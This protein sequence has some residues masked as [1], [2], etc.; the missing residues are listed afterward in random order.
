MERIRLNRNRWREQPSTYVPFGSEHV[1]RGP[2]GHEPRSRKSR[3][4]KGVQRVFFTESKRLNAPRRFVGR[5]GCPSQAERYPE[6]SRTEYPRC[7]FWLADCQVFPSQ[8]LLLCYLAPRGDAHILRKLQRGSV[9][10]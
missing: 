3:C 2:Q 8:L 7:I 1:M 4:E 6:N 10:P 9:V 5:C